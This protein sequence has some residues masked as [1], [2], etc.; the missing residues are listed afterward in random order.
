MILESLMVHIPAQSERDADISEYGSIGRG[1]KDQYG[2]AAVEAGSPDYPDGE[3]VE[4][5][6]TGAVD[7][8]ANVLL[9][10]NSEGADT[11]RVIRSALTHYDAERGDGQTSAS[12]VRPI[13]PDHTQRALQDQPALDGW[14]RSSTNRAGSTAATWWSS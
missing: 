7:V 3:R 9:W 4:A 10:A 6:Q 12:A 2:L 1:C 14:R 13:L 11:G 8:I 5:A